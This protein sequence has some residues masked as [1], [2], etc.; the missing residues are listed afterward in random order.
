MSSL[1]TFQLRRKQFNV[2]SKEINKQLEELAEEEIKAKERR[3][4]EKRILETKKDK[5]CDRYNEEWTKMAKIT[6]EC[7]P[8]VWMAEVYTNFLGIP[9]YKALACCA[10]K[11]EAELFVK[12]Y[13]PVKCDIGESHYVTPHDSS[14]VDDYYLVKLGMKLIV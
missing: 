14:W 11:E 8:T 4:E 9:A 12:E 13:G 2:F 6:R 5:I 3:V 7:Y 10:T 1:E